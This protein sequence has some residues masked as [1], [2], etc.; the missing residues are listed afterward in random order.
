MS[1]LVLALSL[2]CGKEGQLNWKLIWFVLHW[3]P[4]S[5]CFESEIDKKRV[6]QSRQ[7]PENANT[8]VLKTSEQWFHWSGP[9]INVQLFCQRIVIIISTGN[10]KALLWK[11]LM[12]N[13]KTSLPSWW[14]AQKSE[15][16][17]CLFCFDVSKQSEEKTAKR[18][19]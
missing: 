18:E 15:K 7:R 3:L 13:L 2:F 16:Y 8:I 9:C 10:Q 5:L 6:W 4:L 14:A 12:I 17:N 19:K 11:F 1:W